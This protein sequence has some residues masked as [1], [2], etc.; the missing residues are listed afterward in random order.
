MFKNLNQHTSE[1]IGMHVGD[2]TLY[3][4]KWSIVW[5]LRGGLNE[6]DY[7]NFHVNRLLKYIFK[8]QFHPKYRSG[9]KN[10]CY[11]VQ[12][13]KKL[14]ISFFLDAG[15]KPGSKSHTVRIP[16]YIKNSKKSIKYA[17]IRGLF[18]T[19]GC[20]RFQRI[21]NQTK[22]TYPRIEFSSVSI[23]LREDLFFLLKELGF[24]IHKWGRKDYKIA[25]NGINQSKKFFN[26]VSPANKKHLKRYKFFENHGFFSP[27]AAVA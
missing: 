1:L 12:T 9:G 22:H 4:T 25:I 17:F 23:D 19:D 8:T 11:G 26:E 5:E 3:K 14:L 6:K 21:N 2:G 16:E 13:S 24:R 7:Y 18:D 20:I 15:F 27:Y 10:G